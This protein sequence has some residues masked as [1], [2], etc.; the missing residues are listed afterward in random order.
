MSDEQRVARAEE[1]KEL[2]T[3]AYRGQ[4]LAE[5]LNQFKEAHAHLSKVDLTPDVLAKRVEILQSIGLVQSKSGDFE[6][7]VQHCTE[8]LR[9]N[10]LTPKALYFRSI[11]NMHLKNFS[12][13]FNDCRLAMQLK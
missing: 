7:A 4:Q 13:A 2:A 11:A 12:E 1:L 3:Q 10:I 5:A 6:S 8:A 9:L